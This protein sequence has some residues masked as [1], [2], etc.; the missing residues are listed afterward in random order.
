MNVRRY[1]YCHAL[2]QEKKKITSD[3]NSYL[4]KPSAWIF[5]VPIVYSE[6]DNA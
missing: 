2:I 4:Q 3:K 1:K 5:A 6:C